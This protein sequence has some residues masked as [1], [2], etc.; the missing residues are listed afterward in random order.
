MDIPSVL[1]IGGGFAGLSV[2]IRMHAYAR[3]PLVVHLV[4]SSGAFGPGL[5]YSNTD[6]TLTMG[7]LASRLS[8]F[9]EAPTHFLTWL[10]RR[11][12][13]EARGDAVGPE[14]DYYATRKAYGDYLRSIAADYRQASPWGAS[15]EMTHA[16]VINIECLSGQFVALMTDGRRLLADGVILAL[17]H[18]PPS[19]LY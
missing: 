8:A 6:S 2:A 1:I 10:R 12:L 11:E 16:T 4:D 9:D 18:L 19:G 7:G 13:S 5:A 17:G 14:S 15:V 3:S